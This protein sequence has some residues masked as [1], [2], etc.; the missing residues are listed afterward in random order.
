VVP[1]PAKVPSEKAAAQ[2]QGR[3]APRRSL[4]RLLKNPGLWIAMAVL[5]AGV[6]WGVA[7]TRGPRVRTVVAVRNSIEQHLV[8]SGRVWVPTRVQ[9]ATQIPGRVVA[10]VVKEGQRVKRG[11]LLIQLDDAEAQATVVESNVAV[12]QAG[13]RVDQLRH[14]GAVV[15][16]E[17]LRQAVTN[18]DHARTDLART[19]HLAASGVVPPVDLENARVPVA[20]ARAK[21]NAAEAKQLSAA[22]MGADSRI[23]RTSLLQARAQR[24]A[25][26][27]RLAQTKILAPQ[28]ALVLE[29]NVEPGDVVQPSRILLV[30]AAG[31]D[32]MQLTFEADERNFAMIHLGQNARVS[33][34]AFP[35]QVF[36]AKVN[37]VAPSIDPARGSV[38]IRLGIAAAPTF[39]KPDMTVSVDLMV[40]AKAGVLTLPSDAVHG[41]ASTR[42]WLFAVEN[43]RIV[44]HDVSLGIRGE[45][46]VEIVSGLREGLEVALPD[47]RALRVG[48]RVRALREVP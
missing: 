1:T 38:E 28:D 25:S 37:Y 14:V 27:V 36:D 30:L 2:L 18:L 9:I 41:A 6:A 42:P 46:S 31:E 5:L 43:D 35:Q 15:A 45:G 10:V 4:K 12:D 16:N 40:A 3:N 44:R 24:V 39:L 13:A 8:A 29:R 17:D 33:A 21:Q 47:A 32:S 34:D 48:Q 19:E 22:P 11:D 20:L 26:K 23:L 7:R